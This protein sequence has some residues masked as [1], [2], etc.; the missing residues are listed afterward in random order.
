MPAAPPLEPSPV[1]EAT[2]PSAQSPHGIPPAPYDALVARI[3]AVIDVHGTNLLNA[4]LLN[5]DLAF[6]AEERLAFDLQGVL[7][8]AVLTIEQQCRLELEH[9]RRKS[10]DLE[11]YI[12]LAA[13]QDRNATL[14][15]YLLI[16]NLEEFLPIVYTPVVGRAC[17][18]FSHIFRRTRGMWI[19]PADVDRVPEILRN[20]VYKDVRLIVVTDNE[21]ILGLGDQG[22]G[23]MGISIGKL[24]LYTA[25][26]GIHPVA[27]ASDLPRRRHR[28]PGAAL[29][30]ALHRVPAA[31]VSADANT[32]PSSRP[33]SGASRKSGPAA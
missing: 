16:H 20:S 4:R 12:G 18:N 27:D 25:G 24:A 9:L 10:D 33:S 28:Q 32:T 1:T 5:K 8:S 30:P 23:G 19:T 29:R 6:S 22:A 11:R 3:P 15:Y 7:P 21:R 14:F 13:L 31:R 2:S 26:S 17:Q